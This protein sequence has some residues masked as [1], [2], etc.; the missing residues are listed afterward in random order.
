MKKYII[1]LLLLLINLFG[2]SSNKYRVAVL[3]YDENDTYISEMEDLIINL[4]TD[5]I[6]YEVAYASNSQSIQNEQIIKMIDDGYR[7]LLVNAV[8]RLASGS[9]IEKTEKSEVSVIFFNR[10]PLE[11]DMK[12][13]TNA[14]YVGSNPLELG[15]LQ[16][17]MVAD[18]FGEP[19]N[20]NPNHDKNGDGIIQIVILKGEQGH[21]DAEMRTKSSISRLKDLGYKIEVLVTEVCN[22]HRNEAYSA[23]KEIYNAYGEK[24]ELIFSNND[25][26]AVGAIDYLMEEG[27]FQPRTKATDQ[28][29][30]IIGV[31]ATDVGI[32]AIEKGL[33][34]GTVLNDAEEQSKAINQ[35]VYYIINKKDF[36]DFPY[37]L[38]NQRYIY[39]GGK[40]ILS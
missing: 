20:L 9:I 28:P 1:T 40:I 38:C 10:E 30:I 2:C 5:Y 26:M 11:I 35:L 37:E 27:I 32:K 22:W 12:N 4:G 23:M 25:D 29:F 19:N 8:D 16:A 15:K 36:G 6:S 3:I 7:I 21:Q 39:I 17:D 34:Y 24:I 14:Y 33:M 18:L 13:A 31:D